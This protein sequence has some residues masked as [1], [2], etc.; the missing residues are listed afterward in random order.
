MT[1]EQVQEAIAA[2]PGWSGDTTALVRDFSFADFAEALTFVNRVAQIAEEQNHH[3]DIDIRYNKVRLT[4]TS[5][6]AGGV[7]K[8]D[9]RLA[10]S[11]S[12]LEI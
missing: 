3:P 10:S 11:I 5:H 8:R 1:N 6:D 2:M 4:L 7:T 12:K 9:L